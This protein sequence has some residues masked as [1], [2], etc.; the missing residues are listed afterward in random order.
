MLDQEIASAMRYIIDAADNPHPYY[1]N[2]PQEFIVPAV[3]FPQPEIVSR[4]D[5]LRSYAL[6]FSW[7][8]KFFAED[9]GSAHALG[10]A[11]LNA[12]QYRK[13]VVPLIDDAGA[14]TGRGFRMGDPSLR[15]IDDGAVQLAL[16]WNSPRAY[17]EAP[18]QKI[19]TFNLNIFIKSAFE[20]AIKQN[21]G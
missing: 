17:F 13:N 14:L 11:A 2:I 7:F 4:G 1:W 16:N 18:A 9:T 5:T 12:L 21:G 10:L 20:C 19:R 15:V 6:E 8:V 3:F